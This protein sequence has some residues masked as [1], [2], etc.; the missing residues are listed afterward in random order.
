MEASGWSQVNQPPPPLLYS[1]PPHKNLFFLLAA[2]PTPVA[3]RSGRERE[4]RRGAL[5]GTHPWRCPNRDLKWL[6]GFRGAGL[7][8]LLL[9]PPPP[10]T[11]PGPVCSCP[12]LGTGERKFWWSFP[13]LPWLLCGAS[14]R[15]GWRASCPLPTPI[16]CM[17]SLCVSCGCLEWKPRG[18]G[19]LGGSP[20]ACDKVDAEGSRTPQMVTGVEVAFLTCWGAGGGGAA[21]YGALGWI[22]TLLAP[23]AGRGSVKGGPH[24]GTLPPL[25]R[26]RGG[27]SYFA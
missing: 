18:P 17:C 5:A 9:P 7:W 2:S 27:T 20:V 19:P 24:L 23:L 26:G 13:R 21:P 22:L 4:R 12:Q 3:S 14:R 15:V 8:R 11:A 1:S 10:A 25:I 16:T 6:T